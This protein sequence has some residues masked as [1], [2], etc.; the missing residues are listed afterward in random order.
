MKTRVVVTGIGTVAPNGAGNASFLAAIKDG[1]S[2]ITFRKELQAANFGSQIA[3]VPDIQKHP[4]SKN[5]GFLNADAPSILSYVCLAGLE[6]WEDASLKPFIEDPDISSG[7]IIGTSMGCS[8]LMSNKVAPMV[9]AKTPKRLGSRTMEQVMYSS[10]SAMLS[11]LLGLGNYSMTI[12]NVCASG[13]DA[14]L[15]G[16]DRL[17]SGKAKKM[18]VGGADGFSPYILAPMDATRIPTRFFNNDPKAGCR[19][20]SQTASGFVYGCGAGI[21]LIETLESA[22]A[23]GARIY[24]EIKGGNSNCG[25]QR[26]GG[27]MS[28]PSSSGII[29]CIKVA[30]LDANI[31]SHEIDCISGHLTATKADVNEVLNWKKAL[32]LGKED[33]PYINSLKSMTGHCFGASGGLESIAS[34]LEIYHGFV[35]PSINSEDL[36]QEIEAEIGRKAVPTKAIDN[37]SINCIIKASFGFGDVNSC[38][39][40]K[41]F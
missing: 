34:V 23:R 22:K 9:N 29:R 8:E 13:L 33:F 5:L 2:G 15:L 41:K 4:N 3:G 17:I 36:H 11:G 12:S 14:I 30:L 10:P 32:E 40:F 28:A 7:V 20:M 1:R 25:G 18:L 21:L 24:A 38:L 35:H 31:K 37:I 16:Y 26:N 27:T 6:A 39:I 19:P